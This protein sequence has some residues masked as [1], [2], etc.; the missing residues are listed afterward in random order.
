LDYENPNF[1]GTVYHGI[2]KDLFSFTLVP[3]G[4]YFVFIFVFLIIIIIFFFKGETPYL[5]FLGRIAEEKRPDLAIKIAVKAKIPL[6]IAAKIDKVDLEYWEK[7]VKPLIEENCNLVEYIGEISDNEKG[8]F[9]GNA[10]AL[11][12]PI[13]WNE[14]FGLV[15]AESMACG[16]P[17]KF[18]K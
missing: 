16:T 13:Y 8:Q 11:L 5:A 10:R 9:L 6:K 14:P 4:L 18:K 15:L 3:K 1:I 7:E 2:P 12:F 17:V